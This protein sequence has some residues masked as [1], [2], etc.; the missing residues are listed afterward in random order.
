MWMDDYLRRRWHR[1]EV[2]SQTC[3]EPSSNSPT[4]P[5]HRSCRRWRGKLTSPAPTQN[6]RTHAQKCDTQRTKEEEERKEEDSEKK[7]EDEE[8][9]EEEEGDK[10]T[11]MSRKRR[12]TSKKNRR[13]KKEQREDDEKK[14]KEEEEKQ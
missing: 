6:I 11:G 13:G 1:V 8:E 7:G 14:D 4:S 12:R 5:G 10:N 9:L 3:R 2:P